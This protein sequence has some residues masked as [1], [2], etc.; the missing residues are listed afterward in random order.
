[1]SNKCVILLAD[2]MSNKCVM[3]LADATGRCSE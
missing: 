1:M 2:A 3:M